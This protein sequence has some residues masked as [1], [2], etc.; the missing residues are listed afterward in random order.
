MFKFYIIRLLLRIP[1]AGA[2]LY[3]YVYNREV[4]AGAVRFSL[5]GPFGL[6]HIL[7]ALLM[8]NMLVHLLPCGPFSPAGKKQ[9]A[10]HYR[11]VS[12]EVDRQSLR[13][14]V[15]RVNRRAGLTMVVWLGCHGLLL[16]LCLA[17][18]IGPAELIVLS[19]LYLVADLVCM[20]FFCPFQ[21]WL[22]KCRCC[23]DCRIFEW[24]HFMMY[25]PMIF[26]ISFYSYSLFFM[27][28]LLLLKWE[29]SFARRPERFW[30]GA[31]AALQCANCPDKLC[32]VK[33]GASFEAGI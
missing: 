25:T 23:I 21:K 5:S 16:P 18:L 19:T 1:V 28:C 11:P 22:M 10:R 8:L 4:L 9:F 12:A 15:R 27:A 26:F 20:L 7:W 29:I 31:N 13:A 30:S 6:L 3:L 17:G 33:K 2:V 24:G 32:Q 14:Y